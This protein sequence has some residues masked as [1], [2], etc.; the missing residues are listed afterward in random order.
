MSRVPDDTWD[1]LSAAFLSH[2]SRFRDEKTFVEWP[3]PKSELL[4]SCKLFF[5]T[6]LNVLFRGCQTTRKK[7]TPHFTER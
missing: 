5:A 4:F 3:E 7:S 2:T 1:S 6:V